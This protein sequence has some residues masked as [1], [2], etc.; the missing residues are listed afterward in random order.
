MNGR[1]S[2]IFNNFKDYEVI[3]TATPVE[4]GGYQGARANVYALPYIEIDPGI[5]MLELGESPF[6]ENYELYLIDYNGLALQI[7]LV[8]IQGMTEV[9]PWKF[10]QAQM[11]LNSLN[12]E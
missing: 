9:N 7:G 10:D 6:S 11:V 12:F 8:W 1:L 4:F 5:Q 3:E 2:I